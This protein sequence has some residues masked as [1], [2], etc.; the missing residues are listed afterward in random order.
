LINYDQLSYQ[1]PHADI[2]YPVSSRKRQ[3]TDKERSSSKD[4]SLSTTSSRSSSAKKSDGLDHKTA[5]AIESIIRTVTNNNNNNN[6]HDSSSALSNYRMPDMKNFPTFGENETM[7]DPLEFIRVLEDKLHI[8]KV[9]TTS[10]NYVLKNC[11]SLKDIHKRHW[12]QSEIIDKHLIWED[13]GDEIGAKT[14]FI[15]QY[16]QPG[17]MAR[18][19]HELNIIRQNKGETVAAF[20]DRYNNLINRLFIKP[21]EE[22]IIYQT[23]AKF[24]PHIQEGLRNYKL[25]QFNI[26][27]HEDFVFTDIHQIFKAA[28]ILDNHHNEDKVAKSI[29][30][31]KSPNQQSDDDNKSGNKKKK[32]SKD[33]QQQSKKGADSSKE[34]KPKD[35]SSKKSKKRQRSPS[36]ADSSNKQAKK[37]PFDGTCNRCGR[38]GHRKKECYSKF[39]MDGH[40]LDENKSSNV[41]TITSSTP[42]NNSSQY[43]TPKPQTSNSSSSQSSAGKTEDA[44]KKKKKN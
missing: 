44:K 23:E 16:T 40:E 29:F 20:I 5:S 28:L 22:A 26:N 3:G 37:T 1:P 10:Y 2:F 7:S 43:Q 33:A 11:I 14:K 13:N 31:N 4:S 25:S 41:H 9:P 42:A 27:Q 39:H 24:Q 34:K 36:A 32:K 38:V 6:N 12:V 21:D 17:L 18:T 30:S 19:R 15:K 8:Y 35:S